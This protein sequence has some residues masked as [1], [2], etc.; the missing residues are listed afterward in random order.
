MRVDKKRFS[1]TLRFALPERIG[2]VR[3]G[4]EVNDAELIRSVLF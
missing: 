4:V 1:D 2:S 3:V